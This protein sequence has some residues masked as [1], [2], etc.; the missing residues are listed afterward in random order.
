[1]IKQVHEVNEPKLLLPD[2]ATGGPQG[3]T[4]AQQV[5]PHEVLLL[6]E[7][8]H[9]DERVQ[10]DSLAQ[11]PEV[12]AAKEVEVNEERDL[13]AGLRDRPD[14]FGATFQ[15]SGITASFFRL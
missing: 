12:V 2:V 8:G 1:M 11:H 7:H 3:L 13:A 4:P 10:V 6:G 5:V 9:H 15:K 14:E